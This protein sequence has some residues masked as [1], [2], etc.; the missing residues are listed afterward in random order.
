MFNNGG[1]K[2]EYDKVIKNIIKDMDAGK[3]MDEMV[4]RSGLDMIMVKD[5]IQI[6]T[7]HKD[8]DVQGILDRLDIKDL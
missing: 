4:K 8:I 1:S 3:T 6:Y 2:R 5:I 7:T